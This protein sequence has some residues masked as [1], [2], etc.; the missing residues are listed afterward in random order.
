MT[1]LE[2]QAEIIELRAVRDTL[3][4]ALQ[5]ADWKIRDLRADLVR[6]RF[7]RDAQP[8]EPY[9]AGLPYDRTATAIS[10]ALSHSPPMICEDDACIPFPS[11]S[12]ASAN[13][14][15]WCTP[16][17]WLEPS[18]GTETRAAAPLR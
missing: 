9:T 8:G 7:A 13:S 3:R 1:P 15:S 12:I 16:E 6:C 4:A 5:V 14:S 10:V 11:N 2:L 17:P 18:D